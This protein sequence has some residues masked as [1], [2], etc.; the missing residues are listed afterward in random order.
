MIGTRTLDD[1]LCRINREI[2]GLLDGVDRAVY[3]RRRSAFNFVG[4]AVRSRFTLLL[5]DSLGLERA[6]T[7]RIGVAAELTHAASLMHDDCIDRSALRRGIPS[8]NEAIGVNTAIIAAGRGIGFSIPSNYIKELIK[9]RGAH[10]PRLRGW[11]G[12]YVDD[13]TMDQAR[14]LGLD[15]LQGTMVDEVLNATPAYNSGLRKGDVI[16]D[17]D[18]KQIRNG[19][20]LSTIVEGAKPGDLLRMTIRRG[21]QSSTMDVIVGKSPE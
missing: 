15:S 8:L 7:E 11:L 14:A 5:G 3:D 1:S 21:R 19:R 18:G 16:L 4:K 2:D 20:H 6:A 17:V 13:V 10:E 12:I 9:Y